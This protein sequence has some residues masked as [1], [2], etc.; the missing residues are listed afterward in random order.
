MSNPFFSFKQF[1]IYQENVAMKVTTDACILGAYAQSKQPKKI[2]DI[3]SG[4]G[5]LSIMLAQ[6]YKSAEV[7]GIESDLLSTNQAKSNVNACAWHD[8]IRIHHNRIQ[9]YVKQ[10]NYKYDLIICNPP[11]YENQLKSVSQRKKRA[12]HAIDLQF[13][14]LAYA[15][16]KLI[17]EKGNFY[18]IVP[19]ES[20]QRLKYELSFFRVMQFDYLEIFSIPGKPMNR[21]IGGFSK[22]RR[23]KIE[24][25]LTL[26]NEMKEYS[27]FFKH[28][29]RDFYLAF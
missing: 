4:T 24:K 6:R 17:K 20:F 14:D 8:R 26:M 15:I 27:T 12:R 9:D 13:S 28:L 22:T 5:I 1:T 7:D 3:G 29:L 18:T 21:I 23:K 10:I 16:N 11:Y 19:C 2:L 25:K